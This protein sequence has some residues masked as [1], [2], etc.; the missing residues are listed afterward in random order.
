MAPAVTAELP[1]AHTRSSSEVAEHWRDIVDE[2]NAYGEV[3]VTN[4]EGHPEVVLMSVGEFVKLKKRVMEQGMAKVRAELDRELAV[5]NE[6]GSPERWRAIM[7]ASPQEIADA[8]NA[9]EE[10]ARR[11]S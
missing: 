1:A 6:P 2:A 10:A 5:L 7:D 8:A 3:V 9:A 11:S 4:D